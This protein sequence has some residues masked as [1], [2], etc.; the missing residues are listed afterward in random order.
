[1]FKFGAQILRRQVNL[2]RPKA[3]KGFFVLFGDGQNGSP[4]GYEV[5]DLLAGWVQSYQIGPPF[6]MVGTRNWET[7]YF[8]QDDWKVT[9]KL[10]LNLGLRYDLY[11]WPVEVQDRQANFNINTGQLELPTSGNRSFVP[12]GTKLG[13][14]CTYVG[15]THTFRSA[16]HSE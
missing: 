13:Q 7:G 4:T 3:G 8:A 15:R 1:V 14:V 2:F 6:G 12:T 16:P 5:S 9:Q 11:T 10:T